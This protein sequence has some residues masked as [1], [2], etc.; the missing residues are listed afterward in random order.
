MRSRAEAWWAAWFDEQG[1]SWDYEPIDLEGYIP[2]FIVRN[3]KEQ[4]LVEVKGG[5]TALEELQEH[6]E[7]IDKSGWTG[8]VLLVGSRPFDQALGEVRVLGNWGIVGRG[9]LTVGATAS[10]ATQWKRSS[11]Q[12]R[13]SGV[14]SDILDKYFSKECDR[15]FLLKVLGRVLPFAKDGKSPALENINSEFKLDL[16][17]SQLESMVWL[18]QELIEN[19][20]SERGGRLVEN[21]PKMPRIPKLP[22]SR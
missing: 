21:A 2:D 17:D 19:G 11:P 3:G 1:W 8:T 18:A 20:V 13:A 22:I 9:A 12:K 10:N 16:D 14:I 5:V 4:V 6:R 15:D 7:K